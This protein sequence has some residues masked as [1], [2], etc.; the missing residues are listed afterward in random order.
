MIKP[1]DQDIENLKVAMRAFYSAVEGEALIRK[2]AAKITLL[3]DKLKV[4]RKTLEENCCIDDCGFDVYK[5]PREILEAC[6]VNNDRVAR[7]VL[8]AL[9]KE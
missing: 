7:E 4:A 9:D 5:E 3:E 8:A 6:M 1:K 2:Q